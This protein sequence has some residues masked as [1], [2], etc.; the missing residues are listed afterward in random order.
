MSEACTAHRYP[1]R[2]L[3]SHPQWTASDRVRSCHHRRP[4]QLCLQQRFS[5]NCTWLVY[6]STNQ[7]TCRTGTRPLPLQLMPQA[8]VAFLNL[9]DKPALWQCPG[10]RFLDR[11]PQGWGQSNDGRQNGSH[12][13]VAETALRQVSSN[14]LMWPKGSA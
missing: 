7:T 5:H 2:H 6:L 8:G 10:I 1:Q 11:L 4:S 3:I 13:S 14:F 12:D 9:P